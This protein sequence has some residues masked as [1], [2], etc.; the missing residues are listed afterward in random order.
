MMYISISKL[1]KSRFEPAHQPV[2][3]E[4]SSD[5]PEIA[6]KVVAKSSNDTI[7]CSSIGQCITRYMDAKGNFN[8]YRCTCTRTLVL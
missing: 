8:C 2:L 7:H 4:I 1:Y 3:A 6:K 5:C